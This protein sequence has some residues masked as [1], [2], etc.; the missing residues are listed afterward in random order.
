MD[1]HDIPA[2]TLSNTIRLFYLRTKWLCK[3]P[4]ELLRYFLSQQLPDSNWKVRVLIA[5]IRARSHFTVPDSA[6]MYTPTG[7]AVRS[8]CKRH[9]LRHEKITLEA[10][11]TT[12]RCV[13]HA[14]HTP[15]NTSSRALLYFHGGGYVVPL[16][17]QAHMPYIMACAKAARVKV[18]YVLE[19]RLA[20]T[21]KFPGQ[22]VQA[23]QAVNYLLQRYRAE[24]LVMGGDSAGG[25][26]A[27]GVLGHVKAP[28]PDV[29][30]IKLGEEKKRIGAV[31]LL[32]PWTTFDTSDP[33]F[34]R[35][36]YSDHLIG[37]RIVK[38]QPYWIANPPNTSILAEPSLAQGTEW[39]D[40]AVERL[41]VV[42]GGA[43]VLCGPIDRMC[44]LL[45]A[46]NLREKPRASVAFVKGEGEVHVHSAMLAATRSEWSGTSGEVLAWLSS[47]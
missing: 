1:S 34:A 21:V 24:D 31:Y 14:I 17:E 9:S 8:Y 4:Y 43:E 44:K 11:S 39:T 26:L 46:E 29:P 20:P 13:L 38:L 37:P 3:S 42:N 47:L 15:Y 30:L 19:Y 28:H 12:P 40:L 23:A 35:N 33:S 36:Y 5:F 7:A 16:V 18:V 10:T 32:S 22:L 25:N 41:L 2:A 45:G 6:M 27:L